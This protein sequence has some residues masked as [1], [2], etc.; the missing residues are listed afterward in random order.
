M[1]E[2]RINALN[3]SGG[4]VVFSQ[5]ETLLPLGGY[6]IERCDEAGPSALTGSCHSLHVLLN[7]FL[8]FFLVLD[9]R[10]MLTSLFEPA[11]E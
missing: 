8:Q 11:K 7:S 9:N 3:K 5:L 1:F 2:F 4:Q 6:C 10:H